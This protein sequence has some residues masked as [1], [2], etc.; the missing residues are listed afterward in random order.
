ATDTSTAFSS[1]AC[2]A[3]SATKSECAFI[4][5]LPITHFFRTTQPFYWIS[6]S[7]TLANSWHTLAT[8]VSSSPSTITRTTG[9]VPEGRNK[10]LPL[11]ASSASAALM[12]SCTTGSVMFS[13]FSPFTLIMVCGSICISVNASRNVWPRCCKAANTCNAETMPSPVE[14]QS[15]HSRCP[16]DSPPMLQPFC[17]SNSPTYPSP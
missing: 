4:F 9:S 11:S 12:A 1:T 16:E 7:T 10:T 2:A 13:R 15:K 6:S 14:E 8:C 5:Q 17:S 3:H